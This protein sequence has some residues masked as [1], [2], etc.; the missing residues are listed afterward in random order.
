MASDGCVDGTAEFKG[1]SLSVTMPLCKTF[2]AP[3]FG[4]VTD[5]FG[6]GWMVSVSGSLDAA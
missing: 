5:R 4:M 3:P 1:V 2:F 6:I